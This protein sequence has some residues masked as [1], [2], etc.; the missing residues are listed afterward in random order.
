MLGEEGCTC[1]HVSLPETQVL[2]RDVEPF[3]ICLRQVSLPE[4]RV[5]GLHQEGGQGR[6]RV[7]GLVDKGGNRAEDGR[8]LSHPPRRSVF[9]GI[10]DFLH[11]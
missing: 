6:Q 11:S 9:L 10:L 2:L 8:R 4:G 3:A 1:A 5:G 7:L